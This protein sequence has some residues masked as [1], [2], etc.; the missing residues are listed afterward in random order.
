MINHFFADAFILLIFVMLPNLE[1]R[2]P[3]DTLKTYHMSE[4]VVLG[5]KLP[6]IDMATVHEI[7]QK[8]IKL[9]DIHDARDALKFT[10][11][12]YFSRNTKNETTFRLRGFE[13]RQVSVFLDGVPISVPYDGIV[14]ISQLAGDNIENIRISKGVS[15]VLYGANTLGG[16]V[17]II[18]GIPKKQHAFQLRLEGSDQ[19]RIYGAMN[20]YGSLG[21]LRYVT[22]LSF[23]NAPN[24][25]LPQKTKAMLNENGGARD[26]SAF[27]KSSA[28]L[29]LHYDLN[30]THHVGFHV[31]WIKNR[32]NVP[33]NALENRPRYWQFPDWQKNV[34]SLNSEHLFSGRFVLRTVWYY[35]KYKNV[36]QSYDDASYS[37]QTFRYAFK[38]IYDDYSLGSI[39]YPEW[40]ILPFGTSHGVI[41]FKQDVHREKAADNAPFQRYSMETWTVGLEQDIRFSQKLLGKAGAD[42]NYLKP[43]F[44]NNA[45]LRKP[46]LLANGQIAFQYQL[47]D[48][49]TLH[50]SV[51]K[52]SRFPTLKELYSER[53]DRNIPN[54]DLKA[55]HSVNFE[56]GTGWTG[57]KIN[58]TV[59]GFY[60]RLADLIVNRQ[61]GNGL[62]QS[63]NIGRAS[64]WGLETGWQAQWGRVDGNVN[65]TFLNARNLSDES[66]T[67]YLEYRPAH[68]VNAIFSCTLNS[69]LRVASEASYTASQYYQNPNSLKWEKL[70]N[71]ALFNLKANYNFS[72]NSSIYLRINNLT[73]KFYYSEYGIPMPGREIVT[74]FRFGV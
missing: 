62:Q 7:H 56:I 41:S 43:F 52:K 47:G 70:N 18:T 13:Q 44:A 60:N 45:D 12:I 50:A 16:G 20:Y 32:F 27:Q 4:I 17:N 30:S 22:A 55:E 2:T 9:L 35:D 63:S 38:S 6:Q 42:L 46:I 14:D 39:L 68:R 1:A 66:A 57:K 11:G 29:K 28:S 3:A 33:P 8:Q 10:P 48:N 61:L 49:R 64:L 36:L 15:S 74:G 65:Y 24:F 23:E 31:N 69:R 54:P 25:R 40:S 19:S 34:M 37:A 59:S 5:E 67:K 73:D 21:R 51:G 26:N 71:F 72:G 58:F 53:L